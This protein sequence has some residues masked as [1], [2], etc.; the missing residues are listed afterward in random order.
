MGEAK[1]SKRE[2]FYTLLIS[3]NALILSEVIELDLT[4]GGTDS[5]AKAILTKSERGNIMKLFILET[6][7]F[8][9]VSH[10]I[11]LHNIGVGAS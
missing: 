10:I 5:H 4:V 2:M 6:E 1:L 9:A 7:R 8:R 11:N 3:V